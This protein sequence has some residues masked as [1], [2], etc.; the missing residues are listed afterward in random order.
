[1]KLFNLT[2]NDLYCI[3]HSNILTFNQKLM[4]F[5]HCIFNLD[6]LLDNKLEKDYN[7]LLHN[8]DSFLIVS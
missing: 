8:I 1:M 7:N 4:L 5:I 3:N 6:V 2:N